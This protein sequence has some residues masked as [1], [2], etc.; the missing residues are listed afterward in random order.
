MLKP[1]LNHIDTWLDMPSEIFRNG[2]SKQAI[3]PK[4]KD[5][6]HKQGLHQP[7]TEDRPDRRQWEQAFSDGP[8]L[9]NNWAQK[10]LLH[11]LDY[12]LAVASP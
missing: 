2:F 11:I 10:S 1:F 12:C 7:P 4:V 9:R 6:H 3:K 8:A 5:H